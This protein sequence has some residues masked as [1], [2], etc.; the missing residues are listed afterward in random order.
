M[1]ENIRDR[2]RELKVEIAR[3]CEKAGRSP[4]EIRVIVVTKTHPIEVLQACIDA[5]NP[6]I[7][8]NRV[9]EIL[10]KA[11][12]LQGNRT[13][14]LVGH[15]QTNK[16]NK[17][18]PL[19]QW[20]HSVDT[21]KL[22]EKLDGQCRALDKKLNVLVQVNTSGEGSKSGCAPADTVALCEKISQYPFLNFRGLMTIGL[23]GGTEKQT[24]ECFIKLRSIAEQCTQFTGRPCELSMGMSGDFTIAIEEGATMIRIGTYILGSRSQ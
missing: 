4:E 24:R 8:E 10:Q 23:W 22:A 1:V 19:V 13:M 12:Y 16:V 18:V 2:L 15:L 14:H 7:G 21:E 5:G 6:D 17:V 11:P 3:S 20:V 9:W